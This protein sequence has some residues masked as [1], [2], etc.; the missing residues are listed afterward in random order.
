MVFVILI[1]NIG[2]TPITNNNNEAQFTELGI[3]AAENYEK[4]SSALYISDMIIY[5]G[6]LFIGDGDYNK[7]TGPVNIMVYDPN[8]NEWSISGTLPDEAVKRFL[9]LDDKL[10]APGTDPR[11]DWNYGNYYVF[12]NDSWE[13]VRTIPNGIH[14]FDMLEFDGYLFAAIDV[15]PGSIPLVYSNDGG[16]SYYTVDMKKDGKTI[17]TNNGAF[18]RCM[19]FFIINDCLYVT[20]LFAYED[21]SELRYEMYKYEQDGKYFEYLTSLLGKLPINTEIGNEFILERT[22]YKDKAYIATGHLVLTND[23]K[24][25][26]VIKFP[27]NE[28]VWDLYIND[29]KLYVLCSVKKD[30]ETYNISVW[31]NNTGKETDFKKILYFNYDIPATS[32]ALNGNILYFGMCNN[33]YYHEKNGTVIMVKNGLDN[34]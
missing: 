26:T 15:N 3:P 13:T 5:N 18:N 1:C 31:E 12:N 34:T 30:D 29:E 33:T 9:I 6:N 7:N 25:Y 10:V 16:K 32:F 21:G 27:D 8:I 23:M 22:V 11:D 28:T 14:N 24:N 19:D 2:C 20:Y 4:G 17:D